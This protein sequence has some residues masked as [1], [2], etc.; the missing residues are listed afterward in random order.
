MHIQIYA[1]T[2]L[3]NPNHLHTRTVTSCVLSSRELCAQNKNDPKNEML[4]LYQPVS[5]QR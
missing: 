4:Y 2:L 1:N 3:I 5:F